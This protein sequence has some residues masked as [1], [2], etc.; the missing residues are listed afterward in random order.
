MGG[1]FVSV[2]ALQS[3]PLQEALLRQLVVLFARWSTD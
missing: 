2:V 3:T 1:G